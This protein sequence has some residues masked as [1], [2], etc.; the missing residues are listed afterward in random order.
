MP[1]P[2][3]YSMIACMGRDLAGLKVDSVIM[4]MMSAE[5]LLKSM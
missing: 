5:F 1:E 3:M 4:D 2:D